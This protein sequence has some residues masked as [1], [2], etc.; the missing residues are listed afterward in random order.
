[1]AIPKLPETFKSVNTFSTAYRKHLL[2]LLNRKAFKKGVVNDLGELILLSAQ[3]T[4]D[5]ELYKKTYQVLNEIY[6][7]LSKDLKNVCYLKRPYASFAH[8]FRYS[9]PRKIVP[10]SQKREQDVAFASAIL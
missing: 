5:K 8:L 10:T 7:K 1:M 3:S 6:K 9:C 2:K 4:F